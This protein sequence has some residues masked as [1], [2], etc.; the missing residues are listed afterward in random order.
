MNW[1]TKF[2]RWLFYS[3]CVKCD[4]GVMKY[5]R[6]CNGSMSRVSVY[7]CDCCGHEDFYE[8]WYL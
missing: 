5:D 2:C 4:Q 1:L 7:K 8:D 3:K 6:E